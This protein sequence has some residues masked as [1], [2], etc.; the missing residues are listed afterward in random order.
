MAKELTAKLESSTG[1]KD[2][3]PFSAGPAPGHLFLVK[4]KYGQLV[5]NTGTSEA[6]SL[7]PCLHVLSNRSKHRCW[8]NVQ[9]SSLHTAFSCG[10]HTRPRVKITLSFTLEFK[11]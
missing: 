1:C 4:S 11:L 9:V 6:C 7:W 8:G 3:K 5:P 2:W 10:T